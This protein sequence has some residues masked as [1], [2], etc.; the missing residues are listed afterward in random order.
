LNRTIFMTACLM[1]TSALLG[2]SP[3]AV[4]G[5]GFV[6]GGSALAATGTVDGNFTLI[7]CPAGEPCVSNGGGGYS[8]FVTLAGQYPFPNWLPNTSTGQWIGPASGGNENIID[9]SGVYVYQET[10]NLTGF[11]LSTVTLT[12][13]FAT[14]NTGSITL[15]GATVGPSTVAYATLTPFSL[16]SGFVQGI[17]TIDFVVT[18]LPGAGPQNPTGL[19]VEL[20]GTGSL[21]SVPEPAYLGFV[22]VGLAVLLSR[23]RRL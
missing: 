21:A 4:F 20:S 12:G 22:A 9:A 19:F 13:S 17:N 14:D 11:N 1:M 8:P 5:T 2:A 10:F 18:N 6:A 23:G 15:N 7:S 16:T 3:I